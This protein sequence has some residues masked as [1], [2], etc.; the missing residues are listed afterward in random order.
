MNISFLRPAV[1]IV[2]T[3]AFGCHLFAQRHSAPVPMY[4]DPITDGA[5]DPVVFYNHSENCWWMLYT[6]RR[7]NVETADVAYCYGNPIGIAQSDDHGASWYYRG[8]LDLAFERGDN[9][10]W[11]PEIIEDKGT[12]HLFVAYIKGVRNHWGGKATLIHYTSKNLW[13][14]KYRGPL[15]V[16]GDNLI[17]ISIIKQDNGLFRAW[18]KTVNSQI[19]TTESKDLKTWSKGIPVITDHPCEGPKVF[20]YREYYWMLTDEWHGMRVYRSSDL[21][22]WERQ[23]L[24]LDGPS[25]RPEDTPSGA[26]GDVVVVNDRAYVIYFTHPGR[27]SHSDAPLDSYG[28]IPYSLRRSSIQ[29]APLTFEGGT[30]ICNRTQDFD[31]YLPDQENRK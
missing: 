16:G 3:L 14:W 10:F 9:T 20:K 18:Y 28:N 30:L 5:A 27:K 24:I 4:R 17:D 2:A 25:N 7:A 6:Q 19:W 8:T 23:G 31:F 15:V 11:A 13:D 29:C 21:K 26:H 22:T 1:F 12:Y